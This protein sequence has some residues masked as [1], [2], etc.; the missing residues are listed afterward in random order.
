[1]Y[2]DEISPGGETGGTL[3][4]FSLGILVVM[5]VI[6]GAM[7]VAL[8]NY[9]RTALFHATN[10]AARQAVTGVG[11]ANLTRVEW[12]ER[13]LI[14][15]ASIY[16]IALNADDIRVCEASTPN[17]TTESPGLSNGFFSITAQARFDLPPLKGATVEAQVFAR[18]EPF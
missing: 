17:C 1:M 16:G 6:Y 18:N 2:R 14:E 15:R 13:L 5:A 7:A 3:V 10:I 11:D 9:R 4:E 8:F 12:I